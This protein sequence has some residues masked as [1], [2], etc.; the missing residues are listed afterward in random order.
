MYSNACYTDLH[1]L[2]V[3]RDLGAHAAFWEGTP[4]LLRA[5][6]HLVGVDLAPGQ[7]EYPILTQVFIWLSAHLATG[8]WE[9]LALSAAGLAVFACLTTLGL[10]QLAGPKA[11]LVFAASPS[12]VMY[13][14]L[15]WDLLTLPAV[16]YAV[17]LAR[18][19]RYAWAA[20]LLTVGAWTKVWPGFV[21]VPLALHLLARRDLRSAGRL[22]VASIATSLAVNLPL[23][24]VNAEAWLGAY[25]K[26]SVRANSPDTNSVWSFL[27]AQ[28]SYTLTNRSAAAAVT[29]TWA[30][31]IS[32]AWV[33]SRG[34]GRYPWLPVS[35]AMVTTYLLV[36]RVDSPQY[37]LW[38][39]PFLA[40]LPVGRPLLVTFF[41]TDALLWLSYSWLSAY[42][43]P[44]HP[45][46]VALRICALTATTIAF[47]RHAVED[48]RPSR[49]VLPEQRR[50][51]LP[52][53]APT[54]GS[55]VLR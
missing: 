10:Q 44:L 15:N 19:E 14:F 31:I 32:W 3:Q 42:Q 21:L 17:V 1:T 51:Q 35:A 49:D 5:G 43:E 18:K 34:S 26:Q 30:C 45:W 13:A 33:A 50:R 41:A 48:R 46:A 24:L 29:V 39:L 4:R 53:H 52:D 47:L 54:T 38:L 8:P 23:L 6:K 2:W 12:L 36:G 7:V 9:F 11:A 40:L 20:V 27:F 55:A 28:D 16:V 22:G 25:R 37:A